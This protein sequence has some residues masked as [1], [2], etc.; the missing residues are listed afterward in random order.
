MSESE[1]IKNTKFPETYNSLKEKFEK[2]GIKKGMTEINSG[3]LK[4]ISQ[5]NYIYIII[6]SK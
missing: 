5:F 6:P 4:L 2:L 1:V 3:E